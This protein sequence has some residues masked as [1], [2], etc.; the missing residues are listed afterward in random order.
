MILIALPLG[1]GALRLFSDAANSQTPQS[2]PAPLV[3]TRPER[4][5]SQHPGIYNPVYQVEYSPD[6]K[7]LAAIILRQDIRKS[8]NREMRLWNPATGRL[9]RTVAGG[10]LSRFS[11]DSR[12]LA[13]ACFDGTVKVWLTDID[14]L[15]VLLKPFGV[16]T[17]MKFSPDG[18]LLGMNIDGNEI[19][20]ELWDTV[21]GQALIGPQAPKSSKFRIAGDEEL[22][23]TDFSLD[24][25]LLHTTTERDAQ[26]WEIATGQRM[27]ALLA[28]H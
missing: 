20:M 16:V 23:F 5:L 18:D 22:R 19:Y 13:V 17:E 27:F 6:G 11:S 21:A 25:K 24:S 28:P 15:P 14:Q 1:W 2:A 3:V 10:Y 7:M 26:S 4:L 9:R 8:P 12:K